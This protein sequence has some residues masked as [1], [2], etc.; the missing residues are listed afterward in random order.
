[1]PGSFSCLLNMRSELCISPCFSRI[2]KLSRFPA[3]NIDDPSFLIIRYFWVAPP[4]RCIVDCILYTTVLKLLQAQQYTVPIKS[5]FFSNGIDTFAI[6]FQKNDS[7]PI[8]NLCLN[9]P[10]P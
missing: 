8:H 9:R 1:M 2:A 5:H 6:C 10:G 4:S 3:G 7:G